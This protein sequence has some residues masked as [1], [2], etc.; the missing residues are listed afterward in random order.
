MKRKKIYFE[1]LNGLRFLCFL[2]VFFFHSFYH[3][4]SSFD[5]NETLTFIERN[6]FGN[7]NL[8]VNF[9]FVLSGFLITYLLI[10]ERK[11]IGKIDIKNFWLRRIL[12]I[13]P[14][15]FVCVAIGFVG[16]PILKQLL[17]Q[18][19][20]E[21]ASLFS[22]LT[23][24]S[25]FDIFKSGLPDASILG[26]LWSIGVEEQFYLIWP[27]ILSLFPVKR[28][29]IP[30]SLILISSLLYRH[31]NDS[32]LAHEYHTLSCIGDMTI[33]AFAAWGIIQF[34]SFK[35]YVI[36]LNKISIVL[37]YISFIVIYAYRHELL[38]QSHIVRI[39]ERIIIAVVI[40]FIILEQNYSN[41]SFVKMSR[42]KNISK[43]GEITYGLY[44][45]HFIG[46]LIAIKI[47]NRIFE[48][49][50][51]W[52]I[53]IIDTVL[54][55]VFSLIIAKISYAFFEKPFLKLKEKFSYFKMK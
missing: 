27:I 15:Y 32:Y 44:S 2:S 35:K 31:F 30:F 53:V 21:T 18:T 46:I 16:F 23:F 8:G 22:F 17:G 4:D 54:A 13:W 38:M 55:F 40:V 34:T 45:L 37:I 7:G 24:T 36:D 29:W 10:E 48:Q 33:G 28:Y 41:N 12:R 19:S 14:L 25:N 52:H 5:G 1:N 11:L 47:T 50:Q 42:F 26:V 49:E 43:L 6:I 20:N 51:L 39:F 3:D 9:F